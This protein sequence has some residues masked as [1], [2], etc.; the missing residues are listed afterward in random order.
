MVKNLLTPD[1]IARLNYQIES[2]RLSKA[3]SLKPN[4]NPVYPPDM[5]KSTTPTTPS[6]VIPRT[7]RPRVYKQFDNIT[8]EKER[9]RLANL[10]AVKKSKAK[11]RAQGEPIDLPKNTA[12]LFNYQELTTTPLGQEH[13]QRWLQLSNE[14]EIQIQSFKNWLK[15]IN[16]E[17]DV[18]ETNFKFFK[19]ETI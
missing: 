16:A 17:V 4:P 7:G 14:R 10:E 12:K 2:D 19:D 1:Q 15:F 9:K 13:Y 11:K 18:A 5:D 3:R 8:D 6:V